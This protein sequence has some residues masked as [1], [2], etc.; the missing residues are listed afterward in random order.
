MVSDERL[1]RYADVMVGIGLRVEPGAQVRILP[2]AQTVPSS[3][4][5]ILPVVA[6]VFWVTRA[7]MDAGYALITCSLPQVS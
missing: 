6:E 3:V 1:E 4:H 7:E 5:S 2:G